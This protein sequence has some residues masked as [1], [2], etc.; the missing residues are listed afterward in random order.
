VTDPAA[1]PAA[2][3][4]LVPFD[5]DE[6]VDPLRLLLI[7]NPRAAGGRTLRA[8]A[9]V[10]AALRRGQADVRVECTRTLEH[11]DELTAAAAADGRVAV[12]FGGDGLLGRVAGASVACGAVV[13]ALPGGRGNDFLRTLGIP[14]DPVLAATALTAVRERH[15]DLGVANG[16]HFVGIA[17][18]GFDSDVQVLAN[19]TRVVRGGQVYTYAALRTLA[20]WQPATFSVDVDG[21][22]SELVGWSVAAGNAQYYGGGMRYA[23]TARLDDG[24][25][26]VVLAARSSRLQFLNQL[27]RVFSGR[28]VDDRHVTV[29]RARR[30]RVD[31]DRPFQLYADGDPIADLPAE[32]EVAPGAL[33]MLVPRTAVPQ[34]ARPMPRPGNTDKY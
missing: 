14:L 24:L 5:G 19:R 20:S 29:V 8:L 4:P 3:S 21:E 13:A 16:R 26:D 9:D 27:P 6:S 2:D 18:V 22:R 30:L 17:S 33:R 31:A 32:V 12:A 15:L 28:H 11:A 25:L 7:V 34:P 23:P 10:E 1:D